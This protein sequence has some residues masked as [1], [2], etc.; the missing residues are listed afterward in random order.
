MILH[1]HDRERLILQ[2][3]CLRRLRDLDVC[4][5]LQPKII[6]TTQLFQQKKST[7]SILNL[8]QKNLR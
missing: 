8:I 6:K 5:L 4:K 7:F 3:Q 1:F 2:L